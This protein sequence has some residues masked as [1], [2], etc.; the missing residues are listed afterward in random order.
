[1]E[2]AEGTFG[3]DHSL[4]KLVMPEVA[5]RSPSIPVQSA[6]G[7]YHLAW[8]RAHGNPRLTPRSHVNS[9]RITCQ[10]DGRSHAA[11]RSRTLYL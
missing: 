5:D 4:L 2:D 10:C 7:D 11:F 9:F 3:R 6:L 8:T 1:M